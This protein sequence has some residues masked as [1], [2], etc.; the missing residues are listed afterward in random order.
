MTAAATPPEVSKLVKEIDPDGRGV[1]NLQGE[2]Q[3]QRQQ[4]ASSCRHAHR[5]LPAAATECKQLC[6]AWPAAAGGGRGGSEVVCR[7]QVGPGKSSSVLQSGVRLT[8]CTLGLLLLLLSA[9]LQSSW[10]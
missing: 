2:Q 9:F 7:G 10:V 1:I 8:W 5:P 3:Q 4:T 6:S